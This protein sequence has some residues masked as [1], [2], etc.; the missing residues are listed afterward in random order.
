MRHVAALLFFALLIA[1]PVPAQ[2]KPGD[3]ILDFKEVMI[4]VRDGVHCKPSS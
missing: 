4:P 2:E 3:P 1:S